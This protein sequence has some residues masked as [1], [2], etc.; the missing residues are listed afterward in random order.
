MRSRPL[1]PT[2]ASAGRRAARRAPPPPSEIGPSLP[3]TCPATSG[4]GEVRSGP[5]ASGVPSRAVSVPRAGIV[6]AAGQPLAVAQAREDEPRLPVDAARVAVLRDRDHDRALDRAEDPRAD[7]DGHAPAVVRRSFGLPVVTDRSVAVAV[8]SAVRSAAGEREQADARLRRRGQLRVHRRPVAGGPG[9]G[10]G[11]D[12]VAA[13]VA[14]GADDQ[15]DG[16]GGGG[17]HGGRAARGA[18]AARSAAAMGRAG[19]ARS[20]RASREAQSAPGPHAWCRSTSC[21]LSCGMQGKRLRVAIRRRAATSLH[22]DAAAAA[23]FG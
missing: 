6:G 12:R 21:W 20:R 16:E 9:A 17:E 22:R 19:R 18:A 1:V 5:C 15:P 2:F 11:R 23:A 10:V 3:T 8:A 4:I 13:V 7:R 14:A